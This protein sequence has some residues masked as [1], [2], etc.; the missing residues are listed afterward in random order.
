VYA[1]FDV[2]KKRQFAQKFIALSFFRFEEFP[3][4]FR[5]DNRAVN[6]T[7]I[8]HA[9]IFIRVDISINLNIIFFQII[10]NNLNDVFYYSP[11][12]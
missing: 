2:A 4:R 6:W 7:V 8:D 1:H 10:Y 11:A 3:S 9:Y 12:Y 5:I